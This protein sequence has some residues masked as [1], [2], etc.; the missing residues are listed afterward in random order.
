MGDYWHKP[1]ACP[2]FKWDTKKNLAC[3]AGSLAFPSVRIACRYYDQYCANVPGWEKCTMA[4]AMT[5]YYEEGDKVMEK[6]S[7]ED[8]ELLVLDQQKKIENLTNELGRY[9]KK[10]SDQAK[11]IGEKDKLIADYEIA[12]G[13]VQE[14]CNTALVSMVKEFGLNKKGRYTVRIKAFNRAIL[15]EYSLAAKRDKDEYILEAIKVQK[16]EN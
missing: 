9:K 8:L 6:Y 14:T 1:W 11:E 13:E 4:Q 15:N 3:E 5:E 16:P 7:K 12:A 2:Y 10:V